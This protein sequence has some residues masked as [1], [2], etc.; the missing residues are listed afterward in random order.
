MA[1]SVPVKFA[2]K[3]DPSQNGL[4]EDLP[5]RHSRYSSVSTGISPRSRHSSGSPHS[6]V[7]WVN[8]RRGTLPVTMYGPLGVMVI[9]AFG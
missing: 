9:F 2:C 8:R 6:D 4:W 1:V 3:W 5:Q 7:I